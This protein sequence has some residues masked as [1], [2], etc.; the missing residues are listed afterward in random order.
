M[1]LANRGYTFVE[2]LTVITMLG[3][4]IAVLLPTIQAASEAAHRSLCARHLQQL[5]LAVQYYESSFR[6]YPPGTVNDTGPIRSIQQGYH[7]S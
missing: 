3:I 7:H 2:L 6:V 4:L 5:G 1:E